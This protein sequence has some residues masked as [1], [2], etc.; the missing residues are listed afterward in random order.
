MKPVTPA[1]RYAS[2]GVGSQPAL[3]RACMHSRIRDVLISRIL[4]GTYPSDFRFKELNLAREFNVSQA[5]VREALRELVALD[6]VVSEPYR[7]TRVRPFDV[8][9]LREA[10][11]L[12]SVIEARCAELAVPCAPGLCDELGV[13]LEQMRIALDRRDRD[14]HAEAALKFHRR[15]VLAS[16]N[17]TFLRTWDSFIWDVR[18]RVVLRRI[19]DAGGDVTSMY[20]MHE[21][22][23]ERLR[24]DDGPGAAAALRGIFG[25]FIEIFSDS[26]NV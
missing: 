13:L 6:L 17:Q 7:G 14:A 19:A 2:A 23:L 12:R 10:Y 15:L 20:P 4:D 26:A 24:A 25:V 8:D 16:D 3:N 21:A 22:L 1:I 5:P 9:A 18:A 11:E